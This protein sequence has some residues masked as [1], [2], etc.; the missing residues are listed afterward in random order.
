MN[1]YVFG[2]QQLPSK[3]DVVFITGGEKDVLSL[4]AHGFN[5]ICFNS[6][7]AQIPENIIEGLQLRFRHIIILYDSDETGIREAKRQTDALA[8]Y[9]V[10]CLTLPFARGVSRRRIYR[11]SLPWA[12]KQ[13]T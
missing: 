8:Q 6:E 7:T 3:G 9:K 12:M 10:L 4:S 11:T 13:R 1:D 2:F 5:A